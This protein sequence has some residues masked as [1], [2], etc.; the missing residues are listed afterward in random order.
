MKKLVASFICISLVLFLASCS[1]EQKFDG[2]GHQYPPE[3]VE[4]KH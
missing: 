2:E 1:L 4:K 3:G